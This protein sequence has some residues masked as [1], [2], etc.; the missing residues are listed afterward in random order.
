MLI[1]T[2]SRSPEQ[3]LTTVVVRRGWFTQG[4]FCALFVAR[5][6]AI[7]IASVN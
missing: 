2:S 3:T 1:A 5:E 6:L 7:K 4:I